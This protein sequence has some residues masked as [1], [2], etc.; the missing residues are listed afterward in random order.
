MHFIQNTQNVCFYPFL[1]LLPSYVPFTLWKMWITWCIN[2][3]YCF[4]RLFICGYLSSFFIQKYIIFHTSEKY[5]TYCTSK[6]FRH[7]RPFHGKKPFPCSRAGLP[8]ASDGIFPL[9]ARVY[10]N[11]PH[12]LQDAAVSHLLFPF[13]RTFLRI[14]L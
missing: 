7:I 9:D 12:P 13:L 1:S 5:R 10:Q 11:K 8:P 2:E 14:F 6:I 3:V 4:S